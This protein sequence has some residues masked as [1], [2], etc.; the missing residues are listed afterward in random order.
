MMSE[1]KFISTNFAAL[2]VYGRL[3]LVFGGMLYAVAVM[4][5]QNLNDA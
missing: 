3:P 1:H 5:N 4:L 2:L